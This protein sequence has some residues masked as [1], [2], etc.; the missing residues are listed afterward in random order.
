MKRAVNTIDTVQHQL[1]S[2]RRLGHG[3]TAENILM[4]EELDT[5]VRYS[6]V[7]LREAFQAKSDGGVLRQDI[8]TAGNHVRSLKDVHCDPRLTGPV[9]ENRQ[10][11][12]IVER[13]PMAKPSHNISRAGDIGNFRHRTSDRTLLSK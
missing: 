7:V 9:Q 1:V 4:I 13:W 8:T 5:G 11:L 10:Y 2:F 6:V 12:G 3:G